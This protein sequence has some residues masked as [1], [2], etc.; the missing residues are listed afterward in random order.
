MPDAAKPA[1]LVT[2]GWRVVRLGADT[3]LAAVWPSAGGRGGTRSAPVR[4]AQVQEVPA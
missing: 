1:V 4:P 3:P 2:A